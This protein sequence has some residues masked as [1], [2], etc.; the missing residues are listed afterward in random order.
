MGLYVHVPFCKTKC[1]YCD[2]N[3]YQGIE[4]LMEPFLPALTAEIACWGETLAHPAVKSVFFGGGTP[5]YL[6]LGY[7]EKILASIQDSFQVDPAAEITLEAN[8]TAEEAKR[9]GEFRRAGVNRIS[10]GVQAL[11]DAA[12]VAEKYQGIRPAPGYP[13]CPDHTEKAT[14]FDLLDAPQ[15]SGITLTESFAMSPAASVSGFY[16]WHPEARYFGLGKIAR[17]QVEDY[18]KRKG[19]SVEDTERWLAPNLGYQR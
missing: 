14:L 10:L 3:T 1:P 12:L 19:M 7:I 15:T 11:D 2:F 4:N 8:P 17:D 5:S 13:A 16:F 6:P 18:A 9:F